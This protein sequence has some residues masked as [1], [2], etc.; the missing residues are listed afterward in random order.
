M[1]L[2]IAHYEE[3]RRYKIFK[4]LAGTMSGGTKKETQDIVTNLGNSK[5][6]QNYLFNY[7]LILNLMLGGLGFWQRK[8]FFSINSEIREEVNWEN[9][10]SKS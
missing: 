4:N 8:V 9:E 6:Q 5:L 1:K 3:S 7:M 10:N 2:V